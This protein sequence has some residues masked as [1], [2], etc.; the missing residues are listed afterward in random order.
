MPQSALHAQKK[1]PCQDA[2][3]F[4]LRCRAKRMRFYMGL[5]LMDS[6][7]GGG[8]LRFWLASAIGC[9]YNPP[10][11]HRAIGIRPHSF[12]PWVKGPIRSVQGLD[13]GCGGLKT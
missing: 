4:R 8:S 3:G 13:R 11:E 9:C 5:T 2:Y 7:C 12:A 10:A 1:N 6:S